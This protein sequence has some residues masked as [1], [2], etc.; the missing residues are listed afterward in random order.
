MLWMCICNEKL[1]NPMDNWTLDMGGRV[2]RETRYKS[3]SLKYLVRV[4][5][6]KLFNSCGSDGKRVLE[7]A[8]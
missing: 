8:V 3:F 6:L 4:L 1:Y 5:C 7:T 2:P